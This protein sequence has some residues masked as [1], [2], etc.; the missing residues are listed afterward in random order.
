MF[1]VKLQPVLSVTNGVVTDVADEPGGTISVTV[2]DDTGRSYRLAGFNDDNPGTDDGAA[3]PHLRLSALAKIGTSV[4]AG[5]VLGFMGDSSPLPLGVRADVPTD[6]TVEIA[7]DSVAPHIRLTIED[8]DG[9]PVDAYGP[10]IDALFR[11]ACSVGIGPWSGPPTGEL[12]D[13]VTTE[14]TDDNRDIDS[15]W[16]ITSTG[17]VTA[18]GWAAMIYPNEG[19]GWAPELPYGPGAGGSPQ[20]PA[21]WAAPLD[22][23]TP[24]WIEL[25]AATRRRSPVGSVAPAVT[26]QPTR[27][28]VSTRL[29][30]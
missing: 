2:T 17:Q 21:S 19:C 29:I 8:L 4:R 18:T 3:P 27:R 22:L 25:A 10:V 5:Q 13:P 24:I 7:T 28:A 12:H 6:A 30:S 20:V 23:A 14:T 16:V 11:Q 15:E 1:G 9:T 26:R